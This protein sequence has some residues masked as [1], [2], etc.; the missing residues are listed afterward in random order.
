MDIRVTVNKKEM[1]VPSGTTVNSL[2]ESAGYSCRVAVWIN[3]AQLLSGEYAVRTLQDGDEI[4][5]LRLA[6]GG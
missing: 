6:A 3:G 1:V 5:I 4:R 2:L